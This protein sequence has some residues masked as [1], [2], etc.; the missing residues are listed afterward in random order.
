MLSSRSRTPS[1]APKSRKAR[2]GPWEGFGEDFGLG[3]VGFVGFSF[4]PQPSYFY[5][6]SFNIILTA[7]VDQ[8]LWEVGVDL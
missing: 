1:T 3:C 8:K 6:L 4:F 5:S 7:R 2:G